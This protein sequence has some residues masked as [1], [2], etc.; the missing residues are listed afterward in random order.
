MLIPGIFGSILIEPKCLALSGKKGK[1]KHVLT[2]LVAGKRGRRKTLYWDLS[3]V[4]AIRRGFSR[5][6]P[7]PLLDKSPRTNN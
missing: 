1:E 6:A 2:P 5:I 3:G 4:L 7:Y